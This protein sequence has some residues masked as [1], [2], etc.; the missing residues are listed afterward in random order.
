MK[1][2]FTH[3]G[4]F[5]R[6]GGADGQALV[7]Y[8]GTSPVTLQAPFVG[9]FVAP[10]ATIQLQRP[11][12]GQHRGAFFAKNIEVFSDASVDY[13]P[14]TFPVVCDT[15]QCQ[16]G[17]YG[18]TCEKYCASPRDSDQDGV[19]DCDDLCPQHPGKTAPGKCGCAVADTDTDHDGTPDCNDECP[20]D[21]AHVSP[22]ACGCTG[23]ATLKP[24]G[25]SCPESF[26]PGHGAATCSAGGVCGD[27]NACKPEPI[28]KP[29]ET[30][31]S[32]YFLCTNRTWVE[33]A[34]SCA[35]VGMHL[36]RIDTFAE[37][38]RLRQ[39]VPTEVWVG[40]NALETAG[41]WR[42]ADDPSG[43]GEEFWIGNDKGGALENHFAF[44]APHAPG[45]NRCL[46]VDGKTGRWSDYGC[47]AAL[48]YIC[49]YTPAARV[50]EP[51]RLALGPQP[52]PL[53]CTP[54]DPNIPAEPEDS[55]DQMDQEAKD[56]AMGNYHGVAAHA[57]PRNLNNCKP[58]PPSTVCP[59]TDVKPDFLCTTDESC[60]P[61]GPDYVCRVVKQDPSCKGAQ[62]IC[63]SNPRCGKLDCPPVESDVTTCEQVD[64]CDNVAST[65][66]Q[67]EKNPGWSLDPESPAPV[68]FYPS[69]PDFDAS[70]T[71]S[72][73]AAVVAGSQD[74]K[75]GIKNLWCKLKPQDTG[76]VQAASLDT[77]KKGTTGSGTPITFLCST[78]T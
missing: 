40:G 4:G 66:F 43:S 60:L 63:N 7:G 61:F 53:V 19:I 30:A 8:L 57:P 47:D 69:P 16:P 1:S 2:A 35:A 78:R 5:A 23:D 74:E 39:L 71:W 11:D 36:A 34:K 42:W 73:P 26:C 29:L 72:D 22:T 32:H 6:T 46:K 55:I 62:A 25:A 15:C 28:C 9:T 21:P 68:M 31:T 51:P 12:S 54:P 70:K 24:V 67:P 59:L 20:L 38:E 65:T 33:A 76:K 27:P 75:N 3:R 58:E 41:A 37:N 77:K 56:A 45:T 18:P 13:I 52:D 14:F 50:G 17:Y 44:W 49:E 64:L 10:N 48:P